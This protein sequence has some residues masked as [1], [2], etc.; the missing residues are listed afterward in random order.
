MKKFLIL[1]ALVLGIA[2]CQTTPEG[3]DIIVDGEVD[4]KVNIAVPDVET[5]AG[6]LNSA[7]GVFDNGVLTGDNTMRYI[8]QVYYNGNP[9]TERLVKYSD[10]KN[11]SFDVRLVPNRDYRFVVWA[12][13]V[14][15]ENDIDNHYD[16]SD[17]SNIT[18]IGTWSAMDESRDAFTGY[19]D[20]ISFSGTSNINITLKRPF[21][22]LRILTTDIPALSNLGVTPKTATLKY[23]TDLRAAFN[24]YTSEAKSANLSDME[25]TNFTIAPYGTEVGTLFTDYLFADNDVVKF[26][27]TVYDQNDATIKYNNFNTDINVRR[28]YLTTISGNVLTDGSNIQI[29][30]TDAF[31]N[32]GNTTDPDYNV[33]TISSLAELVA[34]IDNGGNYVVISDLNISSGASTLSATA[35]NANTKKTVINLNGKTITVK[36]SGT[37]PLVTVATGNTLTF[38]GEGNILVSSDSTAPFI[39]N[40]GTI[41]LEG[42]TFTPGSAAVI[43][44]T[45]GRT[46]VNGGTPTTGAIDGGVIMSTTDL[47]NEVVANGGSIT[48]YED[49]T[50]SDALLIT[51]TNPITINGNGH[52][53]TSSATRAIR[54]TTDSANVTIEGLNVVVTTERI[55]DSDIR[56]I[57]IDDSIGDVELTLNNCSVDFT[58]NSAYDWSYG[59]NISDNSQS[60]TLTINGG[61]YEG[62]NVINAL[63]SDHIIDV[64]SATL[65]SLYGAN[66]WY[67]GKGVAIEGTGMVISVDNT[68]FIGSNATPIG[69]TDANANTFNIGNNDTDAMNY[70]RF[71]KGANFYYTLAEACV[72]TSD[73][74]IVLI[75]DANL[76]DMATIANGKSITLD[77]NGK[78]IMGTDSST[79]NFALIN[80]QGALTITGPGTIV[81]TANKGNGNNATSTVISNNAN[82]E[83]S[84]GWGVVVEHLGGTD[85]AYSVDNATNGE[86]TSAVTVIDRATIESSYRAVRQILNGTGANNT[87]IIKEGSTI[88]G[89]T[90]SIFVYDANTDA[91]SGTLIVEDGATLNG[92]VYLYV[93]EGT[94][95]WPLDLSI[96][97]SAV[98]GEVLYQNIPIGYELEDLNGTYT[99]TNGKIMEG[100]YQPD[101]NTYAVSNEAGLAWIYANMSANNNYEGMTIELACDIT[102]QNAW[103]PL[104]T[105]NAPFAGT[106]DG[107]GYT[108]S[109]LTVANTDYAAFIAYAAEGITI[110]NLTLE[111]VA[112]QSTK[113]AAGVV[114][115]GGEGVTIN[116]I[117]ISGSIEAVNYAGGICHNISEVTITNCVN[118]ASVSAQ[119]AAGIASWASY[120]A[121]INSVQNYGDITGSIGAS[122]IAHGFAGTIID[123]ANHGDII[124]TGTEP[125]AGIAGVQKGA[126]TYEYCVNYGSVTTTVDN[127]NSSAAGI[128]GQTPGTTAILTYCANHGTI[129]AEQCYAAGIAYSLYGSLSASYCYNDG[130]IAG[131]DGAGG[132]APMA[133]FGTGDKA[134]YCLNGGAVTSSNGIAYQA[135]NNNTS[136]YYYNNG[137]LLNVGSNTVANVNDALTIL[138]GGADSDFFAINNGVISTK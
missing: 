17:L 79:A 102:L 11:I 27:M 34:A 105:A 48:L 64:E 3:L 1:A 109:N 24:A 76:D 59:I 87:I 40:N 50:Y 100:L 47:L 74:T 32:Q 49:V 44:N 41:N 70:Y 127:P 120:N 88:E 63:G 138:N 104:G 137:S 9:S 91:N 4:A 54:I 135:S 134:A 72:A 21:A 66:Q 115:I 43:D 89:V 23:T 85:M 18:L 78:C 37:T 31:A 36:N 14:T 22:K 82:G 2:S 46:N 42:G 122:G 90:N 71:I 56:G 101:D 60:N 124:S 132:I 113:H 96:A 52:T 98:N 30:T 106:F 110:S 111:N 119:R 33:G 116:N 26:E 129:T 20:E 130:T 121:N 13:V 86:G 136:C 103:M 73:G 28:N 80:N 97:T 94:T 10:N 61:S 55:D 114:C 93:T 108:I 133:Q 118:N 19:W 77:L 38:A 99:I 62:A 16:T 39:D 75:H 58:A 83:L 12:D 57:D 29:T 107:K 8:L 123:A 5:R 35:L 15:S 128:L 95:E 7:L 125:A 65:T 131:D 112:I 68:T 67:Y 84:L 69:S 117:T 81:L 92:N 45:D 25:H 6:G 51:T 53:L 126:S